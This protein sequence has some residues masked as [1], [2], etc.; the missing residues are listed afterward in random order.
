VTAS[1]AVIAASPAIH[2]THTRAQTASGNGGAIPLPTVEVTGGQGGAGGPPESPAEKAG[3][4]APPVEQST[5]K[6]AVPIFDLPIA[7][8]TVS[9]QVIIDQNAVDVQQALEN[10]SG[11]RTDNNNIEG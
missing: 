2:G 5:T 10:V 1:L 4:S 11:V 9:E 6:I 7:I 8:A 3:F